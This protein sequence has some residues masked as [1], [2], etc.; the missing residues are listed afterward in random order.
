MLKYDQK[1][2]EAEVSGYWKKEKIPEGLSGERKGR[3]KFYLNDGPPYVNALPHVGH[4]KTTAYKDVWS[5]LKFMQ[6]FDSYF[7][8][9][10]DC[11]GLPIEVIVEQ[12]LGIK[13][14][15]DI[16][17][18][19]I[20]KFDAECLKKV[21][22]NE[23]VWIDYYKKLGAWRGFFEPYFTFEPYYIESAWW[24]AKKLHEKG[25]LVRGKKSIHWCPKCET[26]L[27]GYE[28]S[29][30]YKMVTDPSIFIKFKLKGRDEFL[31]VWTTT[32]W[33]LPANVGIGVKGDEDYVKVEVNGV[34][35]IVAEKLAAKVFGEIGVK[36][37]VLEKV[38]GEDLA[39][40]EYEPL[41]DLPS[42]HSIDK[43][44]NARK[45]WL[46]LPIMKSKKYKKH[47]KSEEAGGG[48]KKEDEE[49]VGEFVT[50]SEGTGF[51]HTAPGHGQTDNL[52]GKHY[53]LPEVSPVDE[54]GK[55]TE[56]AGEFKGLFV[57]AADK[58]IMEKLEKEG[59][60]LH[61]STVS[62]SYPLC[63]RCKSP[64]IFRLSDQ[65]YLT[66]D[67]IKDKMITE[68]RD[69]KWMPSYGKEA[70]ENWLIDAQDWCVSQQRYWGI[71]MP[72]WVC[73][74]CKAEKVIGSV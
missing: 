25:M 27:A 16:E 26:A 45:I 2:I 40:L 50:V 32:P 21:L 17:K 60:L 34:K 11:H 9:G 10:F 1:A 37:K 70:L 74:K 35:L 38:K 67:L 33:T 48:T 62:H 61:R 73:S 19:G 15:S 44:A 46:S 57:K 58:L 72:V 47:V 29:D 18:M 3:K 43:H 53:N 4:V 5:R 41:L 12:D 54:Q 49:E 8:P 68:N 13:A 30:S 28:V 6:G 59:K 66:V 7:Q 42:Q 20:E 52:F 39:G 55:F 64:L 24:T 51:V 31:L 36:F 69:V 65:W 23:S 14:K 22:H 71:P 56:E 63:W